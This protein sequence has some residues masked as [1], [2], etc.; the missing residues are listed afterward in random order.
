METPDQPELIRPAAFLLAT[1]RNNAYEVAKAIGGQAPT[2]WATAVFGP[3]QVAAYA[4]ADD[5]SELVKFIEDLRQSQNIWQLDARICK[6]IPGDEELAPLETKRP[7]TAVLLINVDYKV[8]LERIVT[9]N[10]RKLAGVAIARA[11]WG[12]ADIIAIVEADDREA[13]RNL[14]CDEVKVMK[15]VLSNSTLYCYP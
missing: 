2:T 4:Q 9:L 1:T 15:G 13:M 10:L 5:A 7:E 3:Y 6:V 11:M 12:P 14:I 8:E